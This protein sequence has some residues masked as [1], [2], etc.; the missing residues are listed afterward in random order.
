[1][2]EE[3]TGTTEPRVEN[4]IAP[5][6]LEHGV[7]A[8]KDS[9]EEWRVADLM[10]KSNALPKVF[11]AVPQV[12]LAIQF[13]KQLEI[14]WAV[15]LRQVTI[16]NGTLSMWGEH[17]KGL[18]ERSGLMTAFEEFLFDKDYNKICFKN[19]NLNAEIFGAVCTVTRKDREPSEAVFLVEDAKKAGLWGGPVWTK[20]PKRMLTM[21]ARSLALKNAFPDV[22]SGIAIAEYDFDQNPSA[23]ILDSKAINQADVLTEEYSK[24]A[25]E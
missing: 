6:A 1:M 8:P 23:G 21:R 16:I 12:I 25:E 18:V 3:I 19:K 15:G 14:P 24:L 20:Y 4:K 9:G 10:L 11:T 17:P 7:L 5:I 2:K 22:L 13:L